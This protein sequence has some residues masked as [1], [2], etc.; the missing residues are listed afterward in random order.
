M[1]A[2]N[3]EEIVGALKTAGVGSA[4]EKT[5]VIKRYLEMLQGKRQWAG[6]ASRSLSEDPARAVVE[7]LSV[8]AVSGRGRAKVVEVGSG[9]GLLGVVLAVARPDW[10]LTMVESKGRK[11]AFLAEAAGSL[12]LG[13]VKVVKARAQSLAGSGFDMCVSRAAGRLSDMAGVALPLLRTGGKYVAL[14]QRDVAGE[15]E[16]AAGAIGSR[17][18]KI[19]AV[20]GL[21]EHIEG[22]PESVSLVVIEKM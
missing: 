7:S 6:L 19:T 1:R 11:A 17:G 10:E 3:M 2:D 15:V 12:G 18:G 14:K 22:V 5:G 16:A 9:G 21:S 13:N 8:L 4:E 20:I